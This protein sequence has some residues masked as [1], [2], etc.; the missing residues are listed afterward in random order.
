M[1]HCANDSVDQ[2]PHAPPTELQSDAPVPA[3][4]GLAE[5]H[6]LPRAAERGVDEPVVT[7][8]VPMFKWK[9]LHRYGHPAR[10]FQACEK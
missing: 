7:H 6:A 2:K 4:H 5:D 10:S 3:A 9:D 8:G 1:K